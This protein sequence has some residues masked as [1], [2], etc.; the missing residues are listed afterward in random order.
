MPF[1]IAADSRFNP[2][3][4]VFMVDRNKS[5]K[6]FWSPSS[7]YALVYDNLQAAAKKCATLRFNNPRVIPLDRASSISLKQYVERNIMDVH[8]AGMDAN[9]AGWDGHKNA[10]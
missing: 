4:T 5:K 7:V 9:E 8:E 10:F 1:V 6:A 2:G 3:E